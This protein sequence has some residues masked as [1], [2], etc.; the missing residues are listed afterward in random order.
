MAF[1]SLDFV[2]MPSR[3][4][5]ADVAYFTD[6]LGG[7]LVFAVEGMGARVAMIELSSEGPRILL[8]DHVEG[9]APVLVYRVA[10][11]KPALAE[12]KR[13]GWKK[14]RTFEIPHGPICSFR[15]P[16]GHRIAV[17]QLTRPEVG[18]HFA[19]RRDF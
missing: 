1:E 13:R 6:V 11:L 12:L 9:A 2:Y 17:Y 4:P 7:R 15:T 14:E 19:G 16:G 10:D 18:E 5:V 8:A 3:D